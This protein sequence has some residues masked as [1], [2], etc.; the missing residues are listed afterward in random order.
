MPKSVPKPKPQIRKFA[1]SRLLNL[2]K[3]LEV[4]FISGMIAVFGTVHH[5]TATSISAKDPLAIW[6]SLAFVLLAAGIALSRGAFPRFPR[7]LLVCLGGYLLYGTLRAFGSPYPEHSWT[8][9]R[10]TVCGMS[11][12]LAMFFLAQKQ[13]SSRRVLM[14]FLAVVWLVCVY[15]ILQFSSDALERFYGWGDSVDPIRW[16]WHAAPVIGNLLQFIETDF[17][18]FE[19]QQ[20]HGLWGLPAACSTLGNPN[21]LAGFLV[22]LLPFL[23]GLALANRSRIHR[24][25]VGA[26][27]LVVFVAMLVTFSRG[28][29]LG[30][31]SGFC[32]FLVFVIKQM[33]ESLSKTL[34]PFAGIAMILVLT[35]N[36]AVLAFLVTK[37]L[38]ID[39]TDSGGIGTIGHRGIVYR[40]TG[41]MVSE[42]PLFGVSPGNF[43]IVFPNY[44]YGPLA[45][46]Y[47]WLQSPED[48][49]L[50]HTHCELLEVAADLG[51]VGLIFYVGILLA[52]ATFVWKG[53]KAIPDRRTRWILAG[54]ISGVFG[55]ICQ[56]LFSVNLRWTSSAW[57]FWGFM[58]ASLGLVMRSVPNIGPVFSRTPGKSRRWPTGVVPAAIGCLLIVLI[59]PTT[60]RFTA[61]WLFVR[62]QVALM[63]R[64]RE[65]EKYLVRARDLDPTNSQIEYQL[66]GY[67]FS[68]ED[69]RDS[70]ESYRRV[71]QIRGDVVVVVENMAT[72]YFKLSTVLE[73]DHER[74][75]ALLKAIELFEE[76]IQRHPSFPRLEDYLARAYQRF[77]FEREAREH[78][79]RAIELY[80]SWFGWKFAY[81]YQYPQF[82]LDLAKN[83]F[84]EKDYKSAYKFLVQAEQWGGEKDKLDKF[85]ALLF[86]ADPSYQSRWESRK[87]P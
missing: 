3:W 61:E 72:A 58:G 5:Q 78:R 87:K 74:K 14:G 62:G 8:S 23:I 76:C 40:L 41:H 54:L 73:K 1:P 22:P 28:G 64:S 69:F 46:Q 20:F 51:I 37:S 57:V 70:I 82:A 80:N 2:E 12:L 29:L 85:A 65:T 59:I 32:L 9:W 60:R 47:A 53:W 31:F 15:G 17:R 24:I 66:G 49:V 19:W 36:I 52:W 44:L 11:P 81:L 77:G 7:L 45:E 16:P 38:R 21:F 67:Y 86:R 4:V 10:T 25:C 48:K 30:F 43:S 33:R 13:G 18:K 35:L 27:L 75:E 42:Y 55:V 26:T 56:N 6:Y 79:L 63:N 83:Y 34:R 84:I 68:Q 50:E 39:D 71:R